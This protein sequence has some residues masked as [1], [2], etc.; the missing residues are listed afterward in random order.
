MRF[1][2][3]KKK[4]VE[5]FIYPEDLSKLIRQTDQAYIKDTGIRYLDPDT[6]YVYVYYKRTGQFMAEP[7]CNEL[8]QLL[9]GEFKNRI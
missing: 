2:Q 3:L 1:Y 8:R 4:T 5:K 6:Q 7:M 9:F